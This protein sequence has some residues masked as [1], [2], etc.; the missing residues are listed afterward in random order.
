MF[1]GYAL[2][3]GLVCYAL[4][5]PMFATFSSTI[6]SETRGLKDGTFVC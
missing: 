6:M 3:I 1:V 5:A 4:Y 2:F